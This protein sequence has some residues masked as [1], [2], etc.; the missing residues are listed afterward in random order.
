MQK[1]HLK[2]TYLAVFNSNIRLLSLMTL[3]LSDL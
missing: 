2:M 3:N 1:F